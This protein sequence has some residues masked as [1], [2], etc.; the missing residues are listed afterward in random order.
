[1]FELIIPQKQKKD[2]KQITLTV[3]KDDFEDLRQLAARSNIKLHGYIKALLKGYIDY[4][5]QTQN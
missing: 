2:H 4:S 1:M 3:E 5:K